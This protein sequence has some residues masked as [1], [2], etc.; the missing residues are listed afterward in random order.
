MT[1]KRKVVTKPNSRL[2]LIEK[3]SW[4][5]GW[6]EAFNSVAMVGFSLFAYSVEAATRPTLLLSS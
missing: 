2:V 5:C 6:L 3:L 1:T 4:V